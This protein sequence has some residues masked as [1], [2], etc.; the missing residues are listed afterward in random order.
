M[1][2]QAEVNNLRDRRW[3][4]NIC[5]HSSPVEENRSCMAHCNAERFD[6][7]KVVVPLTVTFDETNHYD[8]AY[9]PWGGRSCRQVSQCRNETKRSTAFSKYYPQHSRRDFISRAQ[10]LQP[11]ADHSWLDNL[12]TTP[13]DSLDEPWQAPTYLHRKRQMRLF[14]LIRGFVSSVQRRGQIRAPDPRR[15]TSTRI[16]REHS[17]YIR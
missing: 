15:T 1:R 2:L 16:S 5:T 6:S 8:I 17:I 13:P 10:E 12:P 4:W 9:G 11:F 14:W 7:R 3:K